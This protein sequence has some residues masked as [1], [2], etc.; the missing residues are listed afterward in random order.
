MER[1]KIFLFDSNTGGLLHELYFSGRYA[2]G[3]QQRS[4]RFRL[5]KARQNYAISELECKIGK[6]TFCFVFLLLKKRRKSVVF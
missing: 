3:N 6:F 1:N 4:S 2:Y 5:S